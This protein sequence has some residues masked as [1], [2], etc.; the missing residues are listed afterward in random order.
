MYSPS[1]G[2]DGRWPTLTALLVRRGGTVSTL[3]SDSRA[4]VDISQGNWAQI[5]AKDAWDFKKNIQDTYGGVLKINAL[6][7]VSM[8]RVLRLPF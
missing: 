8:A 3:A 1:S 6:F 4:P 2:G 5:F 7:G